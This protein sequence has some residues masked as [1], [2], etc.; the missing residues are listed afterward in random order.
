M[1]LVSSVVSEIVGGG[2]KWPPL[3]VRVTKISVAVRVLRCR[4]QEARIIHC[5]FFVFHLIRFP[6]NLQSYQDYQNYQD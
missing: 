5:P 6:R 1:T 4:N 3:A 2:Q